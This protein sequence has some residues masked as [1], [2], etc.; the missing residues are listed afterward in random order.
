[1]SRDCFVGTFSKSPDLGWSKCFCNPSLGKGMI[2]SPWPLG[3]FIEA[4]A[5]LKMFL[6][7]HQEDK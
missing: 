1:M 6:V 5:V 2:S 7:S 4:F 3:C